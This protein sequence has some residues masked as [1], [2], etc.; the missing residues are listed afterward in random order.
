MVER[1]GVVG[2]L[3]VLVALVGL[4][5]VP[6]KSRHILIAFFNVLFA[7]WAFQLG[8]IVFFLVAAA[9]FSLFLA[10]AQIARKVHARVCFAGVIVSLFPLFFVRLP[11]EL[12]ESQWRE[13]LLPVSL[14]FFSLQQI[15]VWAD[16]YFQRI[17][18]PMRFSLWMCY[19]TYFPSLFA[20]PI[21]RWSELSVQLDSP[22][23][24]ERARGW[25]SLHLFI[26][27]TFK[28]SVFAIPLQYVINSYFS[29]PMLY[30]PVATLVVAISFRFFLWAEI[31]AQT[32]WARATSALLGIELPENFRRPF[33]QLTLSDFWRRWHMT[34][35]F[36]LRDYVFFPLAMGPLRR[37]LP[38]AAVIPVAV[39]ITFAFFGLWHG[40]TFG[41]LVMG[42]WK[43][44]GV[45]TTERSLQWFKQSPNFVLRELVGRG[46]F[47]FAFVVFVCAP[48]LLLKL[49]WSSASALASNN[50]AILLSGDSRWRSSLTELFSP[51]SD[52]ATSNAK[53]ILWFVVVVVWQFL[54]FVGRNAD[55]E[56]RAS[57]I[58]SGW[59]SQVRT[60]LLVALIAIWI[61]L[62]RFGSEFR[63]SYAN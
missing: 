30:G 43:G 19:A 15:G 31:S 29:N 39:L 32:D 12:L 53:L 1:I 35:S 18:A 4:V 37:F 45:I 22:Q 33:Q 9:N 36:W 7:A 44:F 14:C 25:R 16:I 28:M 60:I 63:F 59:S 13:I 49:D 6:V 50:I 34:L 57:A 17:T 40:L 56:G 55:D 26:Q 62:G 52:P 47:L 48:T 27:A 10:M 46:L 21:A 54:E 2:F 51:I 20:G 61:L 11:A 42:I 58:G 23:R 3:F 5:N 24:F 41:L 8:A 38:A